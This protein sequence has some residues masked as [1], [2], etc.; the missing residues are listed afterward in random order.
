M[1][2]PVDPD[3]LTGVFDPPE[4]VRDETPP[5]VR[6]PSPPNE[7]PPPTDPPV[8]IDVPHVDPP[9][10]LGIDPSMNPDSIVRDVPTAPMLSRDRLDPN[11]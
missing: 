11:E 1:S 3:S 2:D 4:Q 8:V 10:P 5:P 7:T 9:A 6:V